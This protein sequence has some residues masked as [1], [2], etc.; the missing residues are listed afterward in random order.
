MNMMDNPEVMMPA[1][2]EE[3]ETLLNVEGLSCGFETS[4]GTVHAVSDVSFDIPAGQTVG[5]VGESGCGKSTL[6]RS[7]LGMIPASSGSIRFEGTELAGLSRRDLRPWR[8]YMQLIF[9][10]PFGSLNPRRTALALVREPLDV[11]NIGPREGRR[12]KAL[13]IMERVGLRSEWADRLPHEFSGG[14]RQ[15]LGLARALVLEPRLIICDEPV[16]A[17]DVSIQ[18]QVIN[19]LRELQ[20]ELGIAYLFISHDLA[21]VEHI[22]DRI[23]VMY[24]GRIVESADRDA[25]WQQPLHPYTRALIDVMPIPDPAVSSAGTTLQGEVPSPVSRPSGCA[26]HTRCPYAEPVCRNEVPLL[27]QLTPGRQVACHLAGVDDHGRCY[28]PTLQHD[29]SLSVS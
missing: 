24:L 29:S 7:L 6:G 5:L 12:A 14:Q 27:R 21:V 8:R 28:S 11:L 10:D 17:L 19:L 1:A 9:Q 3:P 2:H 25:L 22:S 15:R 4:H 16:S 13:E 26:F 18:A 23:M 20:Q